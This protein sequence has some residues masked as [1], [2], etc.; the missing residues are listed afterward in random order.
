MTTRCQIQI[1]TNTATMTL[2]RHSNGWPE[3]ILPIIRNAYHLNVKSL[4][5]EKGDKEKYGTAYLVSTFLNEGASLNEMEA[6]EMLTNNFL[7]ANID[8]IYRLKIL[9][10]KSKINPPKWKLEVFLP[11][12]LFYQAN[13]CFENMIPI[14]SIPVPALMLKEG[15]QAALQ[16]ISSSREKIDIKEFLKRARSIKLFKN[17]YTSDKTKR[18]N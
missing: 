3:A 14:K 11:K 17:L 12:A 13:P 7:I 6:F 8:F 18:R 9:T 15:I 5:K 10:D 4:I 2:Y 1:V 16:K